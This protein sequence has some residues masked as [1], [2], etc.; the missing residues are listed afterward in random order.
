MLDDALQAAASKGG[1]TLFYDLA[2]VAADGVEASMRI[3]ALV[4]TAALSSLGQSD[5]A[6]ATSGP[7]CLVVANV[8][9]GDV[10]NMRAGPSALSAIVD[11]LEPGNHGIIH[12]DADCQPKSAKWSSR[13][14]PVTHYLGDRTTKG[15]L[16][17]RYVRDSDCP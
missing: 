9:P 1:R 15:W 12:L 5:S 13:W 10:L 17:T 8:A 14:C 16:K 4:L 3:G 2:N 11:R 7:G 6:F